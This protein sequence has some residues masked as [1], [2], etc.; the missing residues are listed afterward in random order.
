MAEFVERDWAMKEI[1]FWENRAKYYRDMIFDLMAKMLKGVKFDSVEWTADGIAWKEKQSGWIPVTER[2]PE[3]EK[4]VLVYE[5]GN[6]NIFLAIYEDGRWKSFDP[7]YK[8]T[9]FD[10]TIYGHIIAWMPL[11]EPYKEEQE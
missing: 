5:A 9:Y 8:E 3:D 7:T 2:L 6:E 11:P 10:E 1:E 4:A